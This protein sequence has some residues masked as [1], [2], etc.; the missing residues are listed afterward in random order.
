MVTIR[1]YNNFSDESNFYNIYYDVYDLTVTVEIQINSSI[2]STKKI[3]AR[4]NFFLKIEFVTYRFK[5]FKILKNN[6]L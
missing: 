1:L 4:F 3:F 6:N 2:F 5:L